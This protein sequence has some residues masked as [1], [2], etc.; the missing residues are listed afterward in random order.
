MNDLMTW[1]ASPAGQDFM[2]D[3]ERKFFLDCMEA[4]LA[5]RVDAGAVVFDMKIE[6][7]DIMNDDTGPYDCEGCLGSGG[8]AHSPCEAC[9]GTG[10]RKER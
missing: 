2:H 9:N 5:N 8:L 6:A 1:L 3:Y 7:E 4:S 10:E